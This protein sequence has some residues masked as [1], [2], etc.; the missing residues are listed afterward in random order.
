MFYFYTV[1]SPVTLKL[2]FIGSLPAAKTVQKNHTVRNTTN[3]RT[4]QFA[5]P[6]THPMVPSCTYSVHN[7]YRVLTCIYVHIRVLRARFRGRCVPPCKYIATRYLY[8]YTY[9]FSC[10]VRLGHSK[11]SWTMWNRINDRCGTTTIILRPP[12]ASE[13]F[14]FLKTIHSNVMFPTNNESTH[15]DREHCELTTFVRRI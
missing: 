1:Y 13:W 5:P 9:E 11:I 3:Y 10:L 7:T 4:V 14:F 2:Y 8:R 15:S 12:A 6:P